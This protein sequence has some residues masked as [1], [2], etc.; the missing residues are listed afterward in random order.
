MPLPTIFTKGNYVTEPAAS[1]T[2]HTV[3]AVLRCFTVDAPVQGVTD[4]ATVTGLH[5]SS[6]SRLLTQLEAERFVQRDPDSRKYRLGWGLMALTGPL[7]STL[8]VR[9][10]ALP[11]MTDLRD[12]CGETVALTLFDG[13]E[14]ITVEQVPSTHPVKHTSP[15]G[16]RYNT[17]LSASVQVFYANTSDEAV[18]AALAEGHLDPGNSGEFTADGIVD[19]LARTREAGW[20]LNYGRTRP[21][22]VGIAAPVRDHRGALAAALMIAAPLYRVSEAEAVRLAEKTRASAEKLSTRLGYVAPQ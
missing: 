21:D 7:L 17:I 10:L 13:R 1:S 3:A 12:A 15:M 9:R 16:T 8:D 19:L 4:I 14:A 2:V 5:K 20:A 6:V 18:R 11:L 22:E